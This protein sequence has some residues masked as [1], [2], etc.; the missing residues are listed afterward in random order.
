MRPE[1]VETKIIFTPNLYFYKTQKIPLLMFRFCLAYS[2]HILFALDLM[3]VNLSVDNLQYYAIE[4]FSSITKYSFLALYY[5]P[6][7]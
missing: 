2:Y 6:C 3:V 1:R 5:S 7:F 4:Y